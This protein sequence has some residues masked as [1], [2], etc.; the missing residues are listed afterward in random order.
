MF[1]ICKLT[2]AIHQRKNKIIWGKAECW[3]KT[4]L[5]LV[6]NIFKLFF[7]SFS[8]N[9]CEA[10]LKGERRT[11]SKVL[12]CSDSRKVS[13]YQ[14]CIRLLLKITRDKKGRGI[15]FILHFFSGFSISHYSAL[16]G[17]S[18][19]FV[20][21]PAYS[22]LLNACKSVNALSRNQCDGYSQCKV[23]VRKGPVTKSIDN[24]SINA[25]ISIFKSFPSTRL[26][27][28]FAF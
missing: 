11:K 23:M 19:Q 16:R 14:G 5:K 10:Y 27:V 26:V 25:L 7:W 4:W 18:A 8:N 13:K 22:W 21:V 12:I 9:R 28:L 15:A 1:T 24:N 17:Q 3:H 20:K 6:L 2:G